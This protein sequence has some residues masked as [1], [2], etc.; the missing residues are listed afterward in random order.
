MLTFIILVTLAC[1]IDEIEEKN[2]IPVTIEVVTK[3]QIRRL[4]YASARLEGVNDATLTSIA[5]SEI[6]EIHVSEG[7]TVS[8]GTLLITLK[9]D[10]IQNAL[11]QNREAALIA[12]QAARETEVNNYY[13]AMSIFE[14]GG[15][16]QQAMDDLITSMEV[17]DAEVELA[18]AEY[19]R[20]VIEEENRC[21]TAPFDGSIVRIWGCKGGMSAGPLISI[22][23]SESVTAEVLLSEEHI[24]YIKPGL[25]AYF[26]PTILSDSV[27]EGAVYSTSSTIDQASGLISARVR[28]PNQDAILR[29][30]MT[31][32]VSIVLEEI[33]STL[34]V[35]ESVLRRISDGWEISVVSNGITSVRTVETGISNDGMYEILSGLQPGDSIIVLGHDIVAD[36]DSVLVVDGP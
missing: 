32:T 36:G 34:V 10:E 35:R 12:A 29:T 7:D 3:G 6:D 25:T 16:S 18:Q 2:A 21:I 28:I 11:V 22:S 31:G 20:A 23:N 15:I 30:G 14:E 5:N 26:Q 1:G 33:D 17:A 8:E 27:F 9:T 19:M 13:R 24:Q 4:V